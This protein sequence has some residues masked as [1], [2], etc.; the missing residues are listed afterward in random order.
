MGPGVRRDDISEAG[1]LAPDPLPSRSS[2][3]DLIRGP[4]EAIRKLRTRLGG[5]IKSGH[6]D[7]EICVRADTLSPPLL[8]PPQ[9]LTPHRKNLIPAPSHRAHTPLAPASTAGMPTKHSA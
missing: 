1:K 4:N 2:S 8:Q 3:P 7:R 6:D 5:R 9:S